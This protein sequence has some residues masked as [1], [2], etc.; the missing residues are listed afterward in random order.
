MTRTG[1]AFTP[2][3]NSLKTNSGS[4]TSN[5]G[6]REMKIF[7]AE[8]WTPKGPYTA[9]DIAANASKVFFKDDAKVQ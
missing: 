4:P 1:N 2:C 5:R 8:G 6:I 3:T 7:M 9:Q